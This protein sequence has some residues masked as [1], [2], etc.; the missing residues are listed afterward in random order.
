MYI[1]EVYL[2]SENTFWL[3]K[4]YK[5]PARRWQPDDIMSSPAL[6]FVLQLIFVKEEE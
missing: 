6:E 1:L 3:V 2:Y 5:C 4:Q